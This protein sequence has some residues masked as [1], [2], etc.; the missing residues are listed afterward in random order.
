MNFGPALP[1]SAEEGER[2]VSVLRGAIL[3]TS[4]LLSSAAFVAVRLS[5]ACF[6]VALA[7]ATATVP[8]NRIN[9]HH[10]IA[11]FEHAMLASLVQLRKNYIVFR[12]VFQFT[13]PNQ[14]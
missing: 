14:S 12:T 4:G 2:A 6:C 5:A 1:Y 11:P 13:P 8:A 9:I 10:M 7:F 3:R